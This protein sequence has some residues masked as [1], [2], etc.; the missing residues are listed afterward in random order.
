M[1]IKIL[2]YKKIT[3]NDMIY[4]D[5][6]IL[7]I[8]DS[9]SGLMVLSLLYC[10]NFKDREG[11]VIFIYWKIWVRSFELFNVIWWIFDLHLFTN[12]NVGC[13]DGI[14]NFQ[15]FDKSNFVAAMAMFILNYTEKDTSLQNSP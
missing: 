5:S 4:L 15:I 14:N 3:I 12:G 11:S 10:Y 7:D 1:L 9:S 2:I 8:L 13:L 6:L